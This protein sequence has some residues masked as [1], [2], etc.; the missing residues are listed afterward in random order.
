MSSLK[1]SKKNRQRAGLSSCTILRSTRIA[2]ATSHG[3]HYYR[4]ARSLSAL[5]IRFDSII[6]SLLPTYDGDI[7]LCTKGEASESAAVPVLYED[8]SDKHPFVMCAMII[9]K[10]RHSTD[11]GTMIFG[12][13]PGDRTG[14]SVFY[15][16]HEIGTSLHTSVKELVYHMAELMTGSRTKKCIVR[17]GSGNMQ[18]TRQICD[19]LYSV[20]GLVFELELV[21]EH[22]TTPRTRNLNRRGMRDMYSAK[23]IAQR[24]GENLDIKF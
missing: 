4:F 19:E 23:S 7:V 22:Q 10:I 21:D 13:D 8:A 24:D 14:L 20:P 17:I 9:Q 12:I 18:A 3:R 5:G 11:D 6:P 16:G 1:Y 2:I 15:G